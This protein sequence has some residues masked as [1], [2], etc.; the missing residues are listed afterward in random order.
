MLNSENAQGSE[1][2]RIG[3]VTNVLNKAKGKVTDRERGIQPQMV[4]HE[5]EDDL[6][7]ADKSTNEVE[8][9]L[10][11][12]NEII[13]MTASVGLNGEEQ[14]ASKNNEN[15]QDADMETDGSDTLQFDEEAEAKYRPEIKP[16]I[17]DGTSSWY[18]YLLQFELI[19]EFNTWDD[20]TKAVY[21]AANLR[22]AALTVLGDLDASKR[23]HFP[24]LVASLNQRFGDD[25]QE[26]LFWMK[27]N[28]RKRGTNESLPE[29]AHE[30]RKM[31]KLA[32]PT[33]SD[34]LSQELLATKYFVNA[35]LDT[36]M[37]LSVLRAK[38]PS[39][40]A[41]L[42][43]AVENE[44]FYKAEEYRK[45]QLVKSITVDIVGE[46]ADTVVDIEEEVTVDDRVEEIFSPSFVKRR[47]K[48]R[49][50]PAAQMRAW[51]M[52]A[53]KW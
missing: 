22:G 42:Q 29:L 25:N 18:E 36:N 35:L 21:L 47:V 8:N 7:C 45:Q 49:K 23:Q 2:P 43:I 51:K 52:S 10:E 3:N 19:G 26:E 30:I 12:L 24:S 41:A 16:S 6:L 14:E 17:Y 44:A 27:L 53:A 40:D 5:P 9:M 39:L 46:N 38:P 28:T 4:L 13:T 31:V 33:M 50:S 37:R 20:Y 34:H 32:L 15:G 48:K 11:T 1:N